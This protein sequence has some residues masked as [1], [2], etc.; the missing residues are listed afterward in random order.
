MRLLGSRSGQ[1][2]AVLLAPSKVES[3]RQTDLF[4][5]RKLHFS[6]LRSPN[7]LS[8]A[9]SCALLR[10][11]YHMY[12]RPVFT[13]VHP[14]HVL[15]EYCFVHC[16]VCS[17]TPVCSKYQLWPCSRLVSFA[18]SLMLMLQYP[19]SA[20]TSIFPPIRPPHN[21]SDHFLPLLEY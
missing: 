17:K 16:I 5:R 15:V 2:G 4:L 3:T 19:Y 18:A 1:T 14:T 21:I 10:I 20:F 8:N 13:I 9:F 7:A 6:I 11:L 12:L